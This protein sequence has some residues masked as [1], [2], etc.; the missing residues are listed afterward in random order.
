MAYV[1][2]VDEV[3]AVEA[4]AD[5]PVAG[6]EAKAFEGRPEARDVALAGGGEAEDGVAE[7]AGDGR[8]E[9]AEVAAGGCQMTIIGRVRG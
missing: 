9:A 6:T 8:I 3:R 7:L 4:E 5:A 2:D 1:L